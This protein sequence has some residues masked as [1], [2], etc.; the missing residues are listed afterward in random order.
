[1]A[2]LAWGR[3]LAES[4]LLWGAVILLFLGIAALL[5]YVIT[6]GQFPPRLSSKG[7]DLPPEDVEDTGESLQYVKQTLVEALD[8]IERI[9]RHLGIDDVAEEGEEAE[10]VG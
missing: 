9:E 3:D 4:L 6:T 8:R 7:V 5:A 2:L 10:E 1:V